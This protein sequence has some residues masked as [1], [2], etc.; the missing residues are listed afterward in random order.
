MS[1]FL[2]KKQDA[3]CAEPLIEDDEALSFLEKNYGIQLSD[4]WKEIEAKWYREEGELICDFPFLLG[5]IPL[6]SLKVYHKLQEKLNLEG[7]EFL[8]IRI[9][10]ELY[11][12]MNPCLSIKG[13]LNKKQS[14]IDYFSNGEIMWISKYVFYPNEIETSM[15]KIPE[16]YT[17]IFATA[18]FV[19]CIKENHFT[20]M[21]FESCAIKKE[22]F[23]SRIFK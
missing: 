22:S 20:G 23:L 6:C 2:L 14:K 15:F 3:S 18:S 11:Y 13:I 17:S 16:M 7:I 5:T 12:I 9:E 21:D 1:V 4:K 10:N 19:E 8:P